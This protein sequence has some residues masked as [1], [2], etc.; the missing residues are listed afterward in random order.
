LGDTE[1]EAFLFFEAL[2]VHRN[3]QNHQKRLSEVDAVSV[4]A[5]GQTNVVVSVN[6]VEVKITGEGMG[7]YKKRNH[8][9]V[10]RF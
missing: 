5:T 3:S 1:L 10:G 4:A 7:A 6:D 2:E 9:A 8:T